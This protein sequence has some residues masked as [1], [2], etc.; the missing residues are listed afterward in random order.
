MNNTRT[1][2]QTLEKDSNMRFQVRRML[3]GLAWSCLVCFWNRGPLS[4]AHLFSLA[5]HFRKRQGH[6][7]S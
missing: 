3:T 5:Q 2:L 6:S 1:T 4:F 7:C